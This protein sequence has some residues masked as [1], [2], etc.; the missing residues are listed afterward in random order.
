M[1]FPSINV[2]GIRSAWVGNEARTIV[3][4]KV[5]V[6]ID[7]RTVPNTDGNRLAGV[8]KRAYKTTRIHH[9][10]CRTN[11]RGNAEY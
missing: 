4:D 3:P 5:I 9:F 8:G 1:Q 11:S 6:E 10:R 7:I 2:R